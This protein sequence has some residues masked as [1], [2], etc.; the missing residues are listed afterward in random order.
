MN[1]GVELWGW[2]VF[3]LASAM[4]TGFF[5][6]WGFGR[7]GSPPPPSGRD[8]P[9][10]ND[11]DSKAERD[12]WWEAHTHVRPF[13]VPETDPTTRASRAKESA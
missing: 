1:A 6:G 13:G 10:L 11:L 2:L 4:V 9:D 5:L 8:Y 12:R 7:M 3:T